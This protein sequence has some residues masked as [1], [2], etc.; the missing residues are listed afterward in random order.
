MEDFGP[1]MFMMREGL[2]LSMVRGVV[3]PKN[4]LSPGRHVVISVM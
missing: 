2:Y 1:L 4:E 3:V